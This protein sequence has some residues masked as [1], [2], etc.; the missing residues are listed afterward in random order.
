MILDKLNEFTSGVD[1]VGTKTYG[2]FAIDGTKTGQT[3]WTYSLPVNVG[4]EWIS[5]GSKSGET[6]ITL[7]G[8]LSADEKDVLFVHTIST[9][10]AELKFSRTV[11]ADG[12]A[13]T[14]IL[15]WGTD[16][17]PMGSQYRSANEGKHED[18][19]ARLLSWFVW[20]VNTVAGTLT[21]EWQTS[22]DKTFAAANVT[23]IASRTVGGASN[24]SGTYLV[25]GDPLPKGLKRYQRLK[26]TSNA[27][28]PSGKIAA[29]VVDVQGV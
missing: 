12:V 5:I 22:D 26:V 13:Y 2:A 23:T 15:D 20:A 7:K 14:D 27:A 18:D 28:T 4:G 21:V 11:T 3:G 6:D 24:A 16:G 25:N 29:F 19:V 17:N 9:T 8:T 1:T 10:A